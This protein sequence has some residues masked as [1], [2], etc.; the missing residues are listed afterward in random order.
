MTK[1]QIRAN[2]RTMVCSLDAMTDAQT[3][4]RDGTLLHYSETGEGSGI[5]LVHGA[6][7]TARSFE[8]LAE[9]LAGSCRVVRY[10]RRGR[11]RNLAGGSEGSSDRLQ[12]ETEDLIAVIGASGATAVFGLSSGAILTMSAALQTQAI[13]KVAL[14]EPP[15]AIDGVDPADWAD[16]FLAAIAQQRFGRAMALILKGT[17]DRELLTRLPTPFLSL[18]FGVAIRSRAPA[19]NGER[20]H[21]LLLTVPADIAVQRVGSRSLPPFTRFATPAL[22]LGGSRSH[23]KLTHALD[24]VQ[25]ELPDARRVVIQDSGHVA[26]DNDGKPQKVAEAIT[27]FL[28]S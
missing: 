23:R 14:Y 10:D 4:S 5:V 21:D 25:R 8:K 27:L 15:F 26:A 22:L 2:R 12:R 28:A 16:D 20:L 7:Q 1:G 6:M 17:G 11:G 13:E 9:S 19:P 18:L 24:C 3:T